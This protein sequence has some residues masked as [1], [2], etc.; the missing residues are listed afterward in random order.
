MGNC[1]ACI[2]T[3]KAIPGPCE[4]FWSA[5]DEKFG[6]VHAPMT[7]ERLADAVKDFDEDEVTRLL[8]SGV[9]VNHPVDDD[10]HT[11]LDVLM[12]E[13][14]ILYEHA[15]EAGSR[16]TMEAAH[17]AS[18]FHDQH[19]ASMAIMKV[20]K[21]HGATFSRGAKP[22]DGWAMT[23]DGFLMRPQVA[24]KVPGHRGSPEIWLKEGMTSKVNK[25]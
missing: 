3:G 23:K 21:D 15:Y 2:E 9:D 12:M 24:S 1:E 18:N 22:D 7:T 14:S 19:E 6:Q 13:Q 25:A 17:I 4:T 10:G 11:A 8:E 20:L 16:G 5:V